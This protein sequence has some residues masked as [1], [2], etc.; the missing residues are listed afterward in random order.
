MVIGSCSSV[1]WAILA[2]CLLCSGFSFSPL[3]FFLN[4]VFVPWSSFFS[5]LPCFLFNVLFSVSFSVTL[6][7]V[8]LQSLFLS[9][10]ALYKSIKLAVCLL[11]FLPTV[12]PLFSCPFFFL[13]VSDGSL[14][15]AMSSVEGHSGSIRRTFGSQKLLKTENVWLLSE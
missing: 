15:S 8:S 13:A 11:F 4:S 6:F 5:R 12:H 1:Q 9:P 2:W 3:F 7:L 14:Y 10:W